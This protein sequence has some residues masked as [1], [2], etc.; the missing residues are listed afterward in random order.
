MIVDSSAIFAI[1][2]AEPD[3]KPIESALL[4]ANSRLISAGTWIELEAVSIRAGDRI[5]SAGLARFLQAIPFEVVPVTVAQ[6]ALARDAY[7][8]FGRGTGHKARLNFGDCF[9]YALAKETGLPLLFKGN[10]FIH[11]DIVPAL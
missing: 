11:T 9:A 8:S 4:A 3:R 2:R 5:V 7:R 6:A 10:D 1:L